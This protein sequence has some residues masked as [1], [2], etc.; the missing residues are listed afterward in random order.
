[1]SLFVNGN[2]MKKVCYFFICLN[3]LLY[4]I[5]LIIIYIVAGICMS[6]GIC[7]INCLPEDKQ[8]T[9]FETAQE[10][11][12]FN[13]Y[14]QEF[15]VY[16]NINSRTRIISSSVKL[17]GPVNK[18]ELIFKQLNGFADA[19]GK[20]IQDVNMD[21]YKKIKKRKAFK[22]STSV[23]MDEIKKRPKHI[24]AEIIH[25]GQVTEQ[26]DDKRSK[27]IYITCMNLKGWIPKQIMKLTM[28]EQS[29]AVL[30]LKQFLESFNVNSE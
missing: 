19:N 2:M 18:R 8:C 16:K 28:K 14:L 23:D 21:D 4:I 9:A 17:P 25:A 10:A 29:K 26:I 12:N 7:E 13:P 20:I 3:K 22:Y 30:K 1:M 11:L 5:N 6:R 24:R 15:I 27:L